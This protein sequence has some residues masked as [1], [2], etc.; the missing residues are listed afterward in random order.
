MRT[1]RP[2]VVPGQNSLR[3]RVTLSIWPSPTTRAARGGRDP[4]FAGFRSSVVHRWA[5]PVVGAATARTASLSL[6][7]GVPR[8]LPAS[9]APGRAPSI[10]TT[11][12]R[13]RWLR[14]L[15]QLRISDREKIA[16]VLWQVQFPRRK[17]LVS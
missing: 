13:I 17:H 11:N 7:A 8:W 5:E 4:A 15:V 6:R 16:A 3:T 1:G 12:W 2:G 14:V 9:A 10:T